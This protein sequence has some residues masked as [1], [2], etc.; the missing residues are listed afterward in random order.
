VHPATRSDRPRH[1]TN[2]MRMLTGTTRTAYIGYLSSI[3]LPC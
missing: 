1:Q 3:Y 2:H